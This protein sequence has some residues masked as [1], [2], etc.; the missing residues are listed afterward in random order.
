MVKKYRRE[1][2]VGRVKSEQWSF[3][4]CGIEMEKMREK[5]GLKMKN[6]GRFV[7]KVKKLSEK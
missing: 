1:V 4:G 7:V 6:K 3:E 2:Q 5:E